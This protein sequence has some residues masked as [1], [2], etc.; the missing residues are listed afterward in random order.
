MKKKHRAGQSKH[1]QRARS[2]KGNGT[3]N[4]II[5]LHVESHEAYHVLFGNRDLAETIELLSRIKRAKENQKE[6]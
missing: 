2:R 6:R 1:H 5:W 4:N 3:I